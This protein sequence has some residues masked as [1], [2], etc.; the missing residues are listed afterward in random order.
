MLL[1]RFARWLVREVRSTAEEIDE[2]IGDA[3]V[4]LD[5]KWSYGDGRL[6]TW[7]TGDVAEFL[8]D[9]DLRP[10]PRTAEIVPSDLL[11]TTGYGSRLLAITNACDVAS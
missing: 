10:S 7:R 3:G 9:R 11:P 4:A 8:L 6:V 2:L 5:W 1:G